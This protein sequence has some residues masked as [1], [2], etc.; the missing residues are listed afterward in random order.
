MISGIKLK[1]N[2]QSKLGDVVLN[3]ESLG[4]GSLAKNISAGLEAKLHK[5]TANSGED[6]KAVF[7][8]RMAFSRP[9][10]ERSQ[11]SLGRIIN[12]LSMEKSNGDIEISG[13]ELISILNLL[14]EATDINIY[15]NGKYFIPFNQAEEI[16]KK[17]NSI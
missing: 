6:L 9:I 12:W 3:I 15:E 11:N 7:H 5:L 2:V 1:D 13:I 17:L 10:Y 16:L 4:M 8:N 14:D